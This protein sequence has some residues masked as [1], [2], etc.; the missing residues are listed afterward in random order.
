MKHIALP[1][2]VALL[3]MS[4]GCTGSGSDPAVQSVAPKTE[5]PQLDEKLPM[6][7]KVAAVKV[8][9]I[10]QAALPLMTVYKS[11]NCG[12]CKL[13]VDHVQKSGFKVSVI[14]TEDLNPIK[15]KLG[16]PAGL[17]WGCVVIHPPR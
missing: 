6:E 10:Q 12:C 1:C 9:M 17:G 8:D 5:V 13:W 16:V 2:L 11:P 7:Q 3:S 4:A 14:D 15:L